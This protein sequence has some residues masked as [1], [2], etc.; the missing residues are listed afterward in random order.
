M[1]FVRA[2]A[3]RPAVNSGR[4]DR[5]QQSSTWL[6]YLFVFLLSSL[7]LQS[8]LTRL[9]ELELA[10]SAVDARL[11][12][13]VMKN[14]HHFVAG[15]ALISDIGDELRASRNMCAAGREELRTVD[16]ALTHSILRTLQKK[17]AM[18]RCNVVILRLHEVYHLL[19]KENEINSLLKRDEFIESVRIYK[20]CLQKLAQ[21][22]LNKFTCL[23]AL[24]VRF[25]RTA[26][27]ISNQVKG[28]LLSLA[29]HF[30]P[31]AFRN[32]I[33]AMVN[34]GDYKVLTEYLRRYAAVA[35]EENASEAITPFLTQEYIQSLLSMQASQGLAKAIEEANNTEQQGNG[36]V[37]VVPEE[38]AAQAAASAAAAAASAASASPPVSPSL[39][40]LTP[41]DF[42]ALPRKPF[43]HLCAHL[44]RKQFSLAFLTLASHFTE[45]LY[46]MQSMAVILS[47]IVV[48]ERKKIVG[49]TATTRLSFAE[50]EDDSLPVETEAESICRA[51]D[52]AILHLQESRATIWA[53]IC[54]HFV[55]FFHSRHAS[56]VNLSVDDFVRVLKNGHDFVAIGESFVRGG[57]VDDAHRA[58]EG[59]HDSNGV[60]AGS[61]SLRNV[62]ADKSSAYVGNFLNESLTALAA[63]FESETFRPL[64]VDADFITADGQVKDVRTI[65]ENIERELGGEGKTSPTSSSSAEL[66]EAFLAGANPFARAILDQRNEY[67][68]RAREA[69]QAAERK[70]AAEAARVAASSRPALRAPGSGPMRAS[71]LN[72]S[73]GRPNFSLPTVGGMTGGVPTVQPR[74]LAHAQ[75]AAAAASAAG[76]PSPS[77]ARAS[78]SVAAG[79]PLLSPTPAADSPR[80]PF[81]LASSLALSHIVGKYLSLFRSFPRQSLD[82]LTGLQDCV[83]LFAYTF[84]TTFGTNQQA[85]FALPVNTNTEHDANQELRVAFSAPTFLVDSYPTLHSLLASVKQRVELGTFGVGGTGVGP[86]ARHLRQES[87]IAAA[88][89][90]A[91]AQAALAEQQLQSPVSPTVP[92]SPTEFGAPQTLAAA[93]SAQAAAAASLANSDRRDK[94]KDSFFSKLKDKI[95]SGPTQADRDRDRRDRDTAANA[96]AASAASS[97]AQAV[98]T[99]ANQLLTVSAAHPPPIIAKVA[100]KIARELD[101]TEQLHGLVHRMHAIEGVG[102]AFQV[103]EQNIDLI[104]QL[105]AASGT[106][107]A[108]RQIDHFRSYVASIA[109][110]LHSYLL[111]CCAPVLLPKE[112]FLSKLNQCRWDIKDLQTKYNAYVDTILNSQ[113]ATTHGKVEQHVARA[114][115]HLCHSVLSSLSALRVN[116]MSLQSSGG[117]PPALL[118]NLWDSLLAYLTDHLVDAFSRAKKCTTEGRGLMTLDLS[119]LRAGLEKITNT[120]S[121]R[122][123]NKHMG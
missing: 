108:S 123:T 70:A 67:E 71:A 14:Y 1:G 5:A 44:D 54:S 116:E 4:Q 62:L 15:L 41:S 52:A 11:S 89:A 51:L 40:S 64:T 78:F 118:K 79:G 91:Q 82:A 95:S 43:H 10:S 100:P 55:E 92:H 47:D 23:D 112:A 81:V 16:E 17:R 120:K 93:A 24:R 19:K 30:E 110:E 104:A 97:S 88:S 113:D 42:A 107:D 59:N 77:A 31:H 83:E 56:V 37:D 117:L 38:D 119:A 57:A 34:L 7:C 63:S 114:C 33:Q 46:A 29:K 21:S 87:V 22:G 106:P 90:L 26:E 86:W 6:I 25:L 122:Q 74:A 66:F 96:T 53:K 12:S 94:E 102:L 49:S 72:L 27:L 101:T 45:N 35:V 32:L 39:D 73:I 68:M 75:A 121:G 3:T 98:S 8:L 109:R 20:R 2:H 115:S 65:A 61:P 76:S 99:A 18:A 13:Q 60:V 84:A 9:R 69:A 48:E 80:P 50:P 28:R 111:L 85:F 105:V 58:T 36:V 103:I